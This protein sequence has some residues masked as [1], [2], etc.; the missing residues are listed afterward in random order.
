MLLNSLNNQPRYFLPICLKSSSGFYLSLS[1]RF[2]I[3]PS[4]H[5]ICLGLD[6]IKKQ[7]MVSLLSSLSSI[8]CFM[9]L[10]FCFFNL[11]LLSLFNHLT[12]V[13]Y[14]AGQGRFSLGRPR[15][16][17]GPGRLFWG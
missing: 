13:C 9:Q 5:L 3:Y 4:L 2:V 11:S 15:P 7:L 12:R 10:L 1:S 6:L 8:L 17:N 16:S 14:R